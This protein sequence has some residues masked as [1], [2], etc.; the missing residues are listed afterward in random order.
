MK[1]IT[2]FICFTCILYSSLV[3]SQTDEELAKSYF[4]QA[5]EAFSSGE[6]VSAINYL[7]YCVKKLGTTNPK[8]EA[9]YIKIKTSDY[10]F[11]DHYALQTKKHLD[12]FL[13]EA[14]S[15]RPE[16]NEVLKKAPLIKS[17]AEMYIRDF[18][19]AMAA[20]VN[21]DWEAS[22]P[23]YIQ[24]L[25]YFNSKGELAFP[26]V[27]TNG[28]Q[29][30]DGYAIV[31]KF[32]KEKNREYETLINTEGKTFDYTVYEEILKEG[33]DFYVTKY[34]TKKGDTYYS[35]INTK[36]Q[37]RSSYNSFSANYIEEF[38]DN[39]I[40]IFEKEKKIR[41]D[42]ETRYGL[43]DKNGKVIAK[44]DYVEIEPFRNGYAS[45][46]KEKYIDREHVEVSLFLKEDG[47]ETDAAPVGY[48]M[49][50]MSENGFFRFTNNDE[51]DNKW[52]FYKE[53][54]PVISAIYDFVWDFSEG[55]AIVKYD[56]KN[57]IIDTKGKTVGEIKDKFRFKEGYCLFKDGKAILKSEDYKG[58]FIIDKTGKKISKQIDCQ[59]LK[60]ISKDRLLVNPGGYQT[61]IVDLDFNILNDDTV[62]SIGDFNEGLAEVQVKKEKS[63]IKN[64]YGYINLNGDIVIPANYYG[65]EPFLN[66]QAVVYDKYFNKTIISPL[67]KKYTGENLISEGLT[68]ASKN[69]KY[70]FIDEKENIKINLTFEDAWNFKNGRARI[71]QDG[72][73]GF[74]DNKGKMVIP[75]KFDYFVLD[76]SHD[77]Y[78]GTI[79][80]KQG[81][82][83][84]EGE[85][86]V[87]PIYD[88]IYSKHKDGLTVFAENG[89][90]GLLD[91]DYNV[92][93]N[94]TYEGIFENIYS[95]KAIKYTK[96]DDLIGI[97]DIS[98][99]VIFEPQFKAIFKFNETY[100]IAAAIDKYE[101]RGY[102]DDAGNI[103]IPFIYQ[104][105]Y[106]FI[107]SGVAIVKQNNRFGCLDTKG[108]V[109][110]PIVYKYLNWGKE[111]QFLKATYEDKKSNTFKRYFNLKGEY[112]CDEKDYDKITVVNKS[113]FKAY[114]GK[115]IYRIDLNGER[116]KL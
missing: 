81:L 24:D 57:L 96:Y 61:K 49:G 105:A 5:Q 65:I 37:K 52:G 62:I 17:R 42:E 94:A 10:K 30:R 54:K 13:S 101:N 21:R 116:T 3:F 6:R 14:S 88:S 111:F 18:N 53:N 102:I 75:A 64:N 99:N 73:I 115:R 31:N 22:G 97:I 12:N 100:R 8:I 16:Y 70:G 76:S 9:F 50:N 43:V 85:E 25:G 83:T 89:L 104:K 69:G 19:E 27:F 82:Y 41:G 47:T 56:T 15:D 103:V 78:I 51:R 109:V 77:A 48:Y 59:S 39:G 29:F 93:L 11:N 7:D 92:L 4:L 87:S 38:Q 110:I 84:L 98:G 63:Y 108:N 35:I 36:H 107:E 68:V 23:I 45:A 20:N 91:K 28:N 1:K 71:K 40:A 55:L 2:V 46:V 66:G 44:A 79:N 67:L 26:Y 34:R 95:K 58:F 80:G 72:K 60:F 90:K 74:I 86:I 32:Y 113:Y 114:K 106:N 33:K 112:I